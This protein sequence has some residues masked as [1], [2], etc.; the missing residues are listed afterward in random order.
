[1]SQVRRTALTF[2]STLAMCAGLAGL[3]AA[4]EPPLP[5][6][7]RQD[8]GGI[9]DC[10]L[11]I[12]Q[13]AF[14]G[15]YGPRRTFIPGGPAID[16][17]GKAAVRVNVVEGTVALETANGGCGLSAEIRLESKFCRKTGPFTNCGWRE[18]GKQEYSYDEIPTNGFRVFQPIV[19]VA[20]PGTHTYR[21]VVEVSA[22]RLQTA[23]SVRGTRFRGA[24]LPGRVTAVHPDR[25]SS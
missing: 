17:S 3:A 20:R 10:G 4:D 7:A 2:L 15:F 16:S 12:P 5:S 14:V 19:S 9:A 22:N 6:P 24:L 13:Q 8:W 25:S 21:L 1:M 18:W 11:F 23:D